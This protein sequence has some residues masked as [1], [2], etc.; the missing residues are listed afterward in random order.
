MLKMDKNSER[1]QKICNFVL[2]VVAIANKMLGIVL[3]IADCLD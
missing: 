2:S 3:F 1:L